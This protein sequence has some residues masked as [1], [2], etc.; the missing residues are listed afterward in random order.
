M[1][2]DLPHELLYEISSYIN[3][4][5]TILSFSL[6][7]NTIFKININPRKIFIKNKANN[8]LKDSINNILYENQMSM[9]EWKY[10]LLPE[11]SLMYF[12]HFTKCS[13]LDDLIDLLKDISNTILKNENIC[14]NDLMSTWKLKTRNKIYL[15]YNILH[16]FT[17]KDN[18]IILKNRGMWVH[19]AYRMSH[20]R[21]KR[22]GLYNSLTVKALI[23]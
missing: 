20:A 22:C 6:V 2:F 4:S 13:S 9:G 19:S 5:K 18:V 12:T 3:S 16:S 7:N 11:P 23:Y 10:Y 17:L 14:T 1:S 15:S 21:A 8:K